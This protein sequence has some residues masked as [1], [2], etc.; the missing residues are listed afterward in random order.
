MKYKIKNILKKINQKLP[1]VIALELALLLIFSF[2]IRSEAKENIHN[3][4]KIKAEVE[5]FSKTQT[6]SVKTVNSKSVSN[7]KSETKKKAIKDRAIKIEKMFKSII[8]Y[9]LQFDGYNYKYAGRNMAK[10]GA[11]DA[12]GN[13]LEGLDCAGFVN[14]IFT[15]GPAHKSWQ[16]MSVSGLYDEIGGT[17]VAEANMKAGDIIFFGSLSHVAIYIGDG[18]IVHAMDE[19]NGICVTTLYR[20]GSTYSGKPIY[21]IRRV[22]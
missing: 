18:K 7:I 9:A 5:A 3:A 11:K 8:D 16:S 13:W 14:Y 2:A 19:A 12:S 21:D 20:G 1:A 17:H 10:G 6:V 15:H 22:L 4:N